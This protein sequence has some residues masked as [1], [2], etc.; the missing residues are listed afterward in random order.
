MVFRCRCHVHG[1]AFRETWPISRLYGLA[2]KLASPVAPPRSVEVQ[3]STTF[4]RRHRRF[5][6]R[7]HAVSFFCILYIDFFHFVTHLSNRVSGKTGLETV[8]LKKNCRFNQRSDFSLFFSFHLNIL[9]I[10]H[11][12]T[13]SSYAH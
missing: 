3:F 13:T 11:T 5:F 6:C 9:T 12:H 1:F 10:I 4:F 2:R 7:C 8:K